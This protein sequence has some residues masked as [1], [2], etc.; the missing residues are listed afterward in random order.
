[1]VYSHI[2]RII[3]GGVCP[4]E[5]EPKLTGTKELGVDTFLERREMGIIHIGSTGSVFVEGKEYVLEKRECLF[6]GMG[7]KEVAFKSA[8]RRFFPR[9]GPSTLELGPTITPLSGGWPGKTRHLR[10]WIKFQCWN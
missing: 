9:A 8:D 2:D 5:T 6:I 4:T 1:M 7:S 10:T 3:A